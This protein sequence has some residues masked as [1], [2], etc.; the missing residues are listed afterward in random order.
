MDWVYQ[1]ELR[2]FYYII[3]ELL[4]RTSEFAGINKDLSSNVNNNNIISQVSNKP[5]G[6]SIDPASSL[7]AG[8][9]DKEVVQ[10]IK[11]EELRRI[12]SEKRGETEHIQIEGHGSLEN[13]VYLDLK[14]D[15]FEGLECMYFSGWENLNNFA[16]I[17]A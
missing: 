7:N 14:V 11:E 16:T 12:K 8:N 2:F 10:V 9:D 5:D 1:I 17:I 3:L 4:N 6:G 13:P 15:D